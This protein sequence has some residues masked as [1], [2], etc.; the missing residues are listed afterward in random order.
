M[1]NTVERSGDPPRVP[2]QAGKWGEAGGLKTLAIR[3]A[4]SRR[5]QPNVF[6]VGADMAIPSLTCL[7]LPARLRGVGG[8]RYAIRSR[9]R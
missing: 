9:G 1:P 3:D 2:V 4:T 5:A 6:S 8:E 7:P